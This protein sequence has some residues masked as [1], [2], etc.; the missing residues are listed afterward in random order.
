MNLQNQIGKWGI[1]KFS[2]IRKWDISKFEHVINFET[3]KEPKMK[4]I[5][6]GAFQNFRRILSHDKFIIHMLFGVFHVTPR[7]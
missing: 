6:F 4:F 5:D 3:E 2:N 7:S 1:S